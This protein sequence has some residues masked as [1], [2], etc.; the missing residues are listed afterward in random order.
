MAATGA[1]AG[2]VEARLLVEAQLS[3]EAAQS[4]AIIRQ[5]EAAYVLDAAA[6]RRAAAAPH[7]ADALQAAR[8]LA[9]DIQPSSTEQLWHSAVVLLDRCTAAGYQPR[10]PVLLAAACVALAAQTAGLPLD[11]ASLAAHLDREMTAQLTGAEPE[12]ALHSEVQ[13][14]AAALQGNTACISAAH[15]LKTF[16]DR[17]QCN[18]DSPAQVQALLG[19]AL[20]WLHSWLA[21]ELGIKHPPS[22]QVRSCLSRLS[23]THGAHC[24]PPA[25]PRAPN[26]PSLPAMNTL[27]CPAGCC[28][29]VPWAQGA[30]HRAPLALR[31]AHADCVP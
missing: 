28:C 21:G 18:L 20:D 10:M 9:Y 1:A 25:M 7:R 19:N 15:C 2:D 27:P 11:L 14:V 8:Y 4:F 17:M 12:A 30:G 22:L 6:V 13:A 5:Y 31:A 23:C 3:E 24:L 16:A 26:L 29:A